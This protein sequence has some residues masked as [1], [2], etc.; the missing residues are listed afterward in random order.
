[1]D[2]D[3]HFRTTRSNS[4]S[5]AAAAA[6]SSE[7][8]ICFTSRF[9]SSSSA[10]KI[11]SKCLLSPGRAREGQITLSTSLSRRL[12]SSGS[13]KVGQASPA[14]PTGGKK[15]GCAFDNP[16]P[17]SPKV[18]CIGQVRVKTKKQGRKMRARS[19]K[20]RTNSEASF[21]K[22][23]SVVQSSQMN[24]N[25]QQFVANQSSHHNLLRQDSMSN[26]G[27]GFQ[28]ERHSH[29][30]QRWVHLPFTICEALRAFG[31][32]L[33]CFLPCHSSCS[34][35]RES[36]KESKAAGRSEEETESSCGKVFARWLVAV[37]DRDGK[38]RKIELV[39]GDEEPQTEK[40]NG[41]QRRHI[42]D[43]MNFKDEN[44][45]VEKD[46]SRIS[47]C[48]P[49]KNALL[50]M[51]C[52]SDPVKVAELAKRFCEPPTPKLEEHDKEELDEDHEEKKTT[53]NEAKRDESVPVSKEDD[54][55]ERTVKLNLK[56]ESEEEISEES[57]SDTE[58]GE[59]ST[60]MAAENEIDEQ[61]SNISM[62][63]HQSQEETV[64]DRIDQEN[65]Q[66]TMAISRTIPIPIQSHCESEFAQD[67]E[68]LESA[69]ED[70]SKREQDNRTEQREAFEEDE[71]GE[72]GENPTSA[73]LSFETEPVLDETGT[74]F[75]E[76]W[77]EVTETTI[78]E[79]AT[80]EG[81][82]SDTQNDDEMMGPEAEDQS[83]ERET[84]PPEPERKTQ[85]ESPVLPDCLLLMMY[86]PKLSME[87]SKETWVCSRDFI[88][89]VPTREKK[90]AGRNPPPP[91]PPKKREK[92][93]ADNTQT[94]VI[95]PARWSCS[96]PAAAAAATMIEQK[97][98]VRA[99][100]YEPFVLTRC[101]SEPMRSSS[102]LAPDACFWKDRKL[103]P[104]RPATFGIGA[105][106]V[107]F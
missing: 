37:Q 57:V 70:E 60:E 45:V 73:S 30:N 91:P 67:A 3:R 107:G 100:G 53:Q 77:E 42:F 98:L 7:L 36:N 76:N 10:M 93:P 66:E 78:K 104:H 26:G 13:L 48:I 103:E 25:D 8:F 23:E 72:N 69:E 52:R 74:E 47:I 62:I 22:S 15:R 68:N 19:L 80:D 27:N 24:G 81:I 32:E 28:Q 34:S 85:T 58:R 49:P 105:A 61:K 90:P 64:E 38:G 106:E 92:K 43:G 71:N 4:S 102:K 39:V 86:E 51:R 20:R 40:E 54:E 11:S 94:A 84:P 75:D 83:K 87:V 63:N 16:E 82:R 18:T 9:S 65:Q 50:L 14:F 99:K 17:S 101:K 97:K 56:L 1:M 96:F 31:A 35:D 44:E 2:S 89:C 6:G 5:S 95:Q 33:N 59:E 41:S 88:R 55:E 21:R 29:R 12:K 79:K 46:E